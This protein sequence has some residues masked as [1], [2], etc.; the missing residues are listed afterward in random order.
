MPTRN[1]IKQ[2]SE[3]SYYHIYSRG[4]AK[5]RIFHDERDYA[6]FLN[7]FKRYLSVEAAK[8]KEGFRYPSYHARL[9]MLAFCLMPNH[10]HLLVHQED[11]L[12]I[13]DFMRSLMT[14][15]SMYYNR[16]YKRTGPVFEGRYKASLIYDHV[17]LEHISRYIHLNPK[18][19]RTYRYS[20]LPFYVDEREAEWVN[21]GQ[22]MSIFNSS[23]K[24][25][26]SFLE[27]YE[28]HK[29]MLD[30]VKYELANN[31]EAET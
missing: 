6:V 14:S 29:A 30:E 9:T 26:R 1:A 24:E 10:I 2:Y 17:Y 19:W 15:Y 25:Y 21:P 13:A 16:R 11:R 8:S 4:V 18:L 20:S 27:D 23:A 22:I 5:Q 7:L 31:E 12:A 3:D 28:S